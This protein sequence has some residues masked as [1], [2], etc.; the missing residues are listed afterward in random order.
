MA[1]SPATRCGRLHQWEAAGPCLQRE[2]G[3]IHVMRRRRGGRRRRKRCGPCR[4]GRNWKRNNGWGTADTRCELARPMRGTHPLCPF[5]V[6]L[7]ASKDRTVHEKRFI[8]RFTGNCVFGAPRT[9]EQTRQRLQPTTVRNASR[10]NL[11]RDTAPCVT[12]ARP[13]TGPPVPRR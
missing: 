12:P 9:L 11:A 2:E 6:L 1:H 5:S 10:V 7:D 13:I 3:K 4:P 8:G